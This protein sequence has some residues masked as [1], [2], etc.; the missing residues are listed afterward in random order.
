MSYIDEIIYP[1]ASLSVKV[2]LGLMLGR[3]FHR[4]WQSKAIYGVMGVYSFI[5]LGYFFYI[6]FYCGNP[7]DWL[8]GVL[9]G[10]CKGRVALYPTTYIH[11]VSTI[12]IDLLYVVLPWLYI[13]S[14]AQMDFRT[15]V[16]V[17]AILALGSV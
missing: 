6:L 2:A 5:S 3:I 8:R 4:T 17:S 15:K 1:I 7:S 10:T 13:Y 12:L 9:L 11:S 14:N 16:S